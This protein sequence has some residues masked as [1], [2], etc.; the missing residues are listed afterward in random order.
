MRDFS[1]ASSRYVNFFNIFVKSRRVDIYLLR[2]G[3]LSTLEG[4][5]ARSRFIYVRCGFPLEDFRFTGGKLLCGNLCV[6]E[7]KVA[8]TLPNI[9][10][11][12]N[13]NSIFLGSL[14]RSSRST[15]I[16]RGDIKKLEVFSLLL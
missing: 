8:G 13:Y 15:L 3:N 6:F 7:M 1:I 2:S 4:F 5:K 14:I 16:L 10:S 11:K 9:L 12:F